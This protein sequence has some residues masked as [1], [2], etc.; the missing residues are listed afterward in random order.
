MDGT[1]IVVYAPEV[2]VDP[3]LVAVVH[4]LVHAPAHG[5]VRALHECITTKEK[6]PHEVAK[7]GKRIKDG[8]DPRALVISLRLPRNRI[9]ELRDRVGDASPN[10]EPLLD[11]RAAVVV[12]L[13]L[14]G[15][16]IVAH[17]GWRAIELLVVVVKE[18]QLVVGVLGEGISLIL[19]TI[20]PVFTEHTVSGQDH[21]TAGILVPAVT[22]EGALSHALLVIDVD[23]PGFRLAGVA[24]ALDGACRDAIPAALRGGTRQ[25]FAI[26]V[27]VHE[28]VGVGGDRLVILRVLTVNDF[29]ASRLDG[30][31][32]VV[33]CVINDKVP[34]ATAEVN[35]VDDAEPLHVRLTGVRTLAAGRDVVSAA[36]RGCAGKLGIAA[37]VIVPLGRVVH[38]LVISTLLE[39]CAHTVVD[40]RAE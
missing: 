31:T 12:A 4:D 38:Q 29:H 27:V 7:V 18:Y 8:E 13:A 23:L 5:V 21:G 40:V 10:L 16:V 32:R 35:L 24:L 28:L 3:I 37:Q 1:V 34:P 33:V 11:G 2:V 25:L 15:D 30:R 20:V 22:V 39:L 36:L 26:V 14:C 19:A 9:V 6:V 17:L